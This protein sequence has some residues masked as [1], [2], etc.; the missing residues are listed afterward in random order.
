VHQD[1]GLGSQGNPSLAHIRMHCTGRGHFSL[2]QR[3]KARCGK[4]TIS[5][6]SPLATLSHSSTVA[7]D[8]RTTNSFIQTLTL[9]HLLATSI[10]LTASWIIRILLALTPHMPNAYGISSITCQITMAILPPTHNNLFTATIITGPLK[11]APR[12]M[13]AYLR[14]Q[15][16]GRNSGL[17]C[18]C[19]GSINCLP[20]YFD[21]SGFEYFDSVFLFRLRKLLLQ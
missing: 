16:F 17:I 15:L 18:H 21:P 2:R 11:T 1:I 3:G 10:I 8:C 13:A 9:H 19:C 5:R 12:K 6:L 4:Y 14:P 20:C 7:H